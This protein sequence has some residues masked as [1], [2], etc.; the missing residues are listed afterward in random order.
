[1]IDPD[2]MR[3]CHRP[4]CEVQPP[5]FPRQGCDRVAGTAR[6]P[7]HLHL[8]LVDR[9][10]PSVKG[11]LACEKQED[12]EPCHILRVRLADAQAMDGTTAV[13]VA[14]PSASLVCHDAVLEASCRIIHSVYTAPVQAVIVR[15]KGV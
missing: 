11:P 12:V 1:M 9:G 15:G 10:V 3:C 2:T 13:L 5:R 7:A 8:Q 6:G 4:S 14:N